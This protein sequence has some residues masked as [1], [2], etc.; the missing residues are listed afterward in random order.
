MKRLFSHD[1]NSGITR[2]FH[3]D[4]MTGETTIETQS[5]LDKLVDFNHFAQKEQTSLHRWGDGK[6]V[7]TIPLSIW[8]KFKQ[9]GKLNDHAFMRRWL[10][11]PENRMYRRFLGKV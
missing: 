4:E 11:D 3:Y 7:A 1:P 9:E 10:N 5:H 2:Y 6:V 8:L